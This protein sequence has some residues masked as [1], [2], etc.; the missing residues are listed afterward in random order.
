[1]ALTFD[2]HGRER[3]PAAAVS[4]SPDLVAWC[5]AHDH[6]DN[7]G[8]GDART[9][10]HTRTHEVRTRLAVPIRR[11][12]GASHP[13]RTRVY[14]AGRRRRSRS[15]PFPGVPRATGRPAGYG[16]VHVVEVRDL[17]ICCPWAYSIVRLM[18]WTGEAGGIYTM[19]VWKKLLLE[20]QW[21]LAHPSDSE[22]QARRCHY[23][24]RP[25]LLL[26]WWRRRPPRSP[27]RAR[28]LVSTR[29]TTAAP[30]HSVPSSA[31]TAA[32]TT[33]AYSSLLPHV[34]SSHSPIPSDP[35]P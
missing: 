26:R 21:L 13:S 23:G 1:M 24:R 29:R 27:R 17:W 18:D 33:T 16:A 28:R 12:A 10:A 19:A 3:A 31:S 11:C 35:S 6:N 8:V 20:F 34:P 4:R 14:F 25:E 9:H 15:S 7:H 32:F 30:F 22:F 5:P 2:V